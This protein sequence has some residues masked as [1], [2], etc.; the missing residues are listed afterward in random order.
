MC[1]AYYGE[2]E[3]AAET[4]RWVEEAGR[5]SAAFDGDLGDREHCRSVVEGTVDI[6]GSSIFW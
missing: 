6:L 5:R 2:D 1:I 4:L 3:D